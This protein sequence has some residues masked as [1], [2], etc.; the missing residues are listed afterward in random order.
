[1][2]YEKISS[3]PIPLYRVKTYSGYMIWDGRNSIDEHCVKQ[4][5]IITLDLEDIEGK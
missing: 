5:D 3:D 1:M 4:G 2:C